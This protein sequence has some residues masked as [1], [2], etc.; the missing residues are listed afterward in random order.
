[1]NTTTPPKV[2]NPD[3]MQKGFRRLAEALEDTVLDVP[4]AVVGFYLG[5]GGGFH[6]GEA[7]E[8]AGG[9]DRDGRGMRGVEC[10]ILACF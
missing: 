6:G 5:G 4:E 3:Q 8:R 2:I 7:G 9:R 10:P 1:M